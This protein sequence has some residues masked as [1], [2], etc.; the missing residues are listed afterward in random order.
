M[1]IVSSSESPPSVAVEVPSITQVCQA[2]LELEPDALRT[3]RLHFELVR[4]AGGE[5]AAL[6]HYQLA[7][8]NAPD[9]VPAIRGA[10]AVQLALGDAKAAA[11]L[12]DA[13]IRYAQSARDKAWLHYDKGCALADI[14]DDRE[15]ARQ[16]FIEAARLDESNP[17]ILK[18]LRHAQQRAKEWHSLAS[19]LES[20]ANAINQDDRHRAAVLVQRARVLERLLRKPH[21]AIEQYERALSL[22]PTTPIALQELK[23]LLFSEQ[24]WGEL[25][26]AYEREA[27]LSADADTQ[28]LAWWN[29]ARIHSERLGSRDDA[30]AALENAARIKQSD[31]SLLEE[32]AR[33]Y[34]SAGD[35]S[36]C[37]AALERLVAAVERDVDKVAVVQRLAELHDHPEGDFEAAMRW[38]EAALDIDAGFGPALRAL[39]RLYVQEGKWAQQAVMYAAEGAAAGPSS[40]RAAAHARAGEVFELHLGRPADASE[41]YERALALDPNHEEAFKALVRLHAAAR[42]HRELIELYDRAVDGAASPDIAIAYLFK[43]ASLYEDVLHEVG[44]AVDVYRRIIAM[45]SDHL[46]AIHALQRAADADGQYAVLVE[47]LDCEAKLTR[48]SSRLTALQHRAG[49]VLFDR[50]QDSEAA[51]PRFEAIVA[52]NAKHLPTLQSMARVLRAQ[53]RH[54]ALMSCYEQQ[55]Q[56]LS[57]AAARVPLLVV[58]GE[59]AESELADPKQAIDWYRDA[60]QLDP[61]HGLARAALVRLLRLEGDHRGLAALLTTQID[62][63]TSPDEIARSAMLLGEVYEV[64]LQKPTKAIAAYEKARDAVPRYRP[65]IDALAR[66]HSSQGSW[67]ELGDALMV[68]AEQCGDERMGWDARLRAAV[69]HSDRLGKPDAACDIVEAVVQGDPGNLAALLSLERLY[70]DKD[71]SA[72]LAA[73]LNEEAGMFGQS[74]ARVASLASRGRLIEHSGASD[75]DEQLGSICAAILALDATHPWA[76]GALGRLAQRLGDLK[77]LADVD[78]RTVQ[79]VEDPAVRAAHFTRLGDSLCTSDAGGARSAYYAA[80][81]LQPDNL[82][83]IRGLS[84]VSSALSDAGTLV[85]SYRREA[86]W[87]S[88]HHAAADLLVMASA[89]LAERE[90][91]TGAVGDA[92]R[93]LSLCPD[94]EMA[95]MQLRYL[96]LTGGEVERLAE[97][98]GQA[99]HRASRS[100]R[101]VALWLAVGSIHAD[102]RRDLGAAKSAVQRALDTAPSDIA[103]I[104]QMAE[105]HERDEQHAEAAALLGR[106][107]QIDDSSIDAHRRLARIYTTKLADRKRATSSLR[108]VLKALPTDRDALCLQLHLHLEEGHRDKADKVTKQLLEAAGDDR[109]PRAWALVEIGRVEL[110]VGTAERAAKVLNQAVVLTGLAGDA[111]SLYREVLGQHE[112]WHRYVD[113]L[114][115]HLQSVQHSDGEV[116]GLARIFVEIAEVQHQQLERPADALDTLDQGL[117]LCGGQQVMST[118]RAEMLFVLGRHA[119]AENALQAIIANHPLVPDVWRALVRALQHQARQAEAS[120]AAAPLVLLGVA[121]EVE[122]NLNRERAIGPGVGAPGSFGRA[123]MRALSAGVGADDE[124]VA[125]ALSVVADGLGK[126]YPPQYEVYGVR[127]SDR[128]KPRT[129]HPMRDQVDGLAAIFGIEEFELFV[130]PGLGGDVTVEL[131]D[132]PSIM[133]PTYVSQ[134]PDAQRV[135]LLARPLAAVAA[136]LH[137]ALKLSA[138]DLGLVLAAAVR[139]LVP[140]FEEGCHDP[141]RLAQLQDLLSPSWFGRGRVDEAVQQY[142]AEPVDVAQWAP[143]VER[144][145]TRAAA[146]LAGDLEAVVV[147]LRYAGR[148]PDEVDQ[149]QL[150]AQTSLLDD[151]LRFWASDR[152]NEVRRLARMV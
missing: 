121:N 147:G 57:D 141:S 148:L 94:H 63:L 27:A 3:A 88:D 71:D 91:L 113:A 95:A 18:A 104:L 69:L 40:K 108:K 142:Y 73:A 62:E 19:V 93:A 122:R 7:L 20:E 46:G 53:G 125:A 33:L 55:L 102:R 149:R 128:I 56:V 146:L 45:Q 100:E 139:R 39:E 11:R 126:A 35:R 8:K 15:A 76:L 25:V 54:R 77:L 36:G 120:H 90:D 59:V 143:L 118:L 67:K 86:E 64:H 111:A 52:R 152:A 131:S 151:L 133:V 124:L 47:A 117:S 41:H 22:D 32:L 145:V 28:A 70:V 78:T 130:H 87:R 134:L 14:E 43:I 82:A 127:K 42:R 109:A 50:L 34:R 72:L 103:P 115:K 12:F 49:D 83:A 137:P 75:T 79:A 123:T 13:E 31:P 51:L 132:P 81:K 16:C 60:L 96:L 106:A 101:K 61:N 17:T 84:L 24:R 74:S 136:G 129:N 37:A 4:Q 114:R 110:E 89:V 135:F 99:A 105:L 144:T 38:Y 98:L 65:A 44:A 30:I 112:P 21:D 66:V 9:F 85:D 6:K 29:I 2:E 10:R 140:D 1:A 116:A 138:T 119:D 23:R 5:R 58:M 68:E 80:L 26:G 48:Q 92:E 150:V 107:V 97:Q